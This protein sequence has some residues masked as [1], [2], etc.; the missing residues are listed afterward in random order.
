MLTAR[1]VRRGAAVRHRAE[2]GS[3]FLVV[4][5]VITVM[6]TLATVIAPGLMGVLEFERV[7]R[8]AKE[9]AIHERSLASFHTHVS[10]RPQAMGQLTRQI[11]STDLNSCG[12]TYN[13]QQLKNDGSVWQGPY[14][15]R[16]MP[17]H[18]DLRL[19]IGV[20][21]D[22]LVRTPAVASNK[23]DP[24]ELAIRIMYVQQH[25]A[26]AL[27]RRV[28]GGTVSSGAGKIRWG[29]ADADGFVT[30]SY[31]MAVAGC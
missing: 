2:V 5:A 9:L 26:E 19:D 12:Q 25:E 23:N 20:V 16:V 21:K 28:D 6:I 7:D 11:V 8:A 22:T 14:M 24:G 1:R 3:T 15:T 29:A 17:S 31:T 27:D 10:A 18:G 13:N 30:V 4:L